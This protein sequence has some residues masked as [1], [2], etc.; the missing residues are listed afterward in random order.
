MKK[1]LVAFFLFAFSTAL[2]AQRDANP[3]IFEIGGKPIYKSE[4]MKE[5][6]QSVGKDPAAAPTACTYEKRKAL[7]DYVQLFVN[8]RT[9]LVDAYA[10][11]LDTTASLRN[12]LA[13]YRAELAA[14]Y[15]LDSA[16]MQVLLREAY[17]RNH[18]ALHAAH[19]LVKCSPNANPADTLKAL[20][21]AMALYRR[22]V[23][24]GADF[25]QV[26]IEYNKSEQDASQSR[27]MGPIDGDLGCFTAFDMVYPFENASY[28][29]QP[30]E[31]SKPVR[32]RFGYHVIKLIDK[33][34]YYGRTSLRHIWLSENN[35]NPQRVEN[36]IYAVY[37]RLE[38]G[39][40]F[41]MVARHKNDDRSAA[42]NGGLLTDMPLNQMPDFYVKEISKGL[43]PGQYSKPFHTQYG[44]HIIK[45][46]S[47]EQIPP[48]ED[49]VPYYKQRLS[50][51]QRNAGCQA[52]FINNTKEKY[53][54]N[55][56]TQEY[57]MV[58]KG[59]K[60]VKSTTPMANLDQVK[61][62]VADSIFVCRWVYDSSKITDTTAVMRIGKKRFT[63]DDFAR[64]L[65]TNQKTQS[66]YD[67]N[68]YVDNR[69]K[70]F[71][72][73]MVFDYADSQLE[74]E[75]V[76]FQ[77]LV[78]EYRHGLMIFAYN[79][80][81]VWTQ[82][83]IDTTGFQQF[84]GIRSKQL[85][86]DNPDD[87]VYFWN[88]RAR[89]SVYSVPDTA[90]IAPDKALPIINKELKKKHASSEIVNQL[91]KKADKTKGTISVNLT[92][93]EE[94]HQQLLSKNEWNKGVYVHPS[95]K[96][97]DVLVV[98][99]FVNPELK[100]QQEAR[101][102]YINDFQNYLDEQLI[103]NLRK[104]YNVIIHQDVIDEITY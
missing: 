33:M 91:N 81:M 56:F 3:V 9:K 5:F 10:I 17:E 4:F 62:I 50:R 86:L 55:D 57:T 96:G 68:R 11:G 77:Q 53:G 34:P 23:D 93:V 41:E 70:E 44:W 49:I 21:K 59:K 98:E 24:S 83:I 63:Q 65:A 45:V 72:D 79:D 95:D 7:E 37:K 88:T 28:A 94:N 42:R 52:V 48:F 75:N 100:S 80:R 8:F 15:L 22:I 43:K 38:S 84:Y 87:S 104:K 82:A 90:C 32:T 92:L 39:E 97:Y 99:G 78:E 85:S 101:G 60:M 58:K 76:E 74:I 36:D 73:A 102:Y 61:A 35:N 47:Q 14:P 64:W 51:D 54:F 16:S 2:F 40:P 69:Y 18:Y 19:I 67:L 66:L 12:E 25:S 13:T 20:E 27:N 89:V 30:G 31:V 26:A 71:V 29:L 103:T 46:E 6:L 1:I